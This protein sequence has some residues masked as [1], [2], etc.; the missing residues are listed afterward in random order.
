[1]TRRGDPMEARLAERLRLLLLR[2]EHRLGRAL[3]RAE[4]A[5]RISVSK[6][7]L[8]AYLKG[9]TVPRADVFDRL[10][11]ELDAEPAE[12]RELSTLR[13]AI[14]VAQH[15]EPRRAGTLPVP[16]QL[17]P[18]TGRFA[19]RAAE[20]ERLAGLLAAAG[21]GA[22]RIA[23]ID[24][25]A[26]VG[27]TTLALHWAHRVRRRYPDGQLHVNLRGFD[28]RGPV[29]PGEVL[30]GFLQA[31]GVAPESIPDGLD[32]KA[33]LYRSVLA[34]R[35][36][37]VVL[38]NAGSAEDVRPL[39]PGAP[40]CLVVVTSRDR[41]DSL[42]VREGAHRVTLD[43][44][45]PGEARHLLE[46][47]LGEERVAGERAAAGELAAL[48]ARL[49]LALSIV[50]ARATR[51]PEAS[52]AELAARLRD[53]PDRLD[54]LGA[55]GAGAAD[56]DLGAVFEASYALL[57]APAAR[58]FRLL[59]AHAGPDIDAHACAA[60]LG[61]SRPPRAELDAL[62]AAHMLEEQADGRYCAHDLLRAFAL[63]LAAR[64]DGAG[65]R[66]AL[67]RAADHYLA[68]AIRAAGRLE[69]CRAGELPDAGSASPVPPIDGPAEAMAWF[70][71][72]LPV[73]QATME[74]AA[75]A[76]LDG[77]VWRL[78]WAAT[79][80]LR[81]TGRR[82]ERVAVHR[83]GLAAA[84]RT[85][86][87][88]VQAVSM[89]LLADGLARLGERAEARGLLETSLAECRAIGDACGTFQ[90]HLSLTRLHDAAGA[91]AAALAHA[92]EALRGSARTGSPLARAD[93]LTA[94]TRQRERLGR[95]GDA[96]PL[97]RRAL[98][99]Y[100]RVGYAEGEA[101]ALRT[102]G[103]IERR[104]GMPE[105]AIVRFEHSLELDRRLGDRFWAAHVLDDLADAHRAAGDPAR[106]RAR[107][108]ESLALFEAMRHPAARAVR[109]RLEA[110]AG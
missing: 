61:A 25:T 86:D 37:L 32:A 44:L 88:L 20:L 68:A 52:L 89:R 67:R 39:L 109:A 105:R 63:R 27:K 30:H 31:L 103:R 15:R 69:P 2:R 41:L 77:H 3:A 42:V 60:L 40:S 58:L 14:E 85:G 12:M 95:H 51:R 92:E 8:Y 4:L 91:H 5:R 59:G 22:A 83:A 100:R 17:P 23:A 97:G 76:G 79:V 50:A 73:L 21:P 54:A 101:D 107:R 99:L 6:S 56:L 81:R 98:G 87:R 70:T 108:A 48:C 7:S 75:A 78:A 43:V 10:L 106:A 24:G 36:V 66:A 102:I 16:R 26:G 55:G 38:D 104:L 96:L 29:D 93:A 11:V 13:D 34:D 35:R 33:A 19:G 62:T 71:A 64:E 72:E 74:Q 65:R 84:R 46:R 1:M 57:P 28:P 90:A 110:D 49:P 94:V 47:W 9:T 82:A 45:P 80:F 18:A 53:L